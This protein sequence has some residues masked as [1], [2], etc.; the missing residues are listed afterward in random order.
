[1][2]FLNR[3]K[4]KTQLNISFILIII[5]ITFSILSI[6]H[7]TIRNSFRNHE[8]QI[9]YSFGQQIAVNI[10]SRTQ[11]FMS[12][13]QIIRTNQDF[14]YLLQTDDFQGARERLATM[15]MEFMSLNSGRVRDITL[16]KIHLH[17]RES[18]DTNRYDMISKFHDNNELFLGDYFIT[19]TFLNER[20]ERVFSIF[21]KIYQTNDYFYFVEICIY[22][23][24]FFIFFNED[25]SDSEIFI[26]KNDYIM[27][28]NARRLFDRVLRYNRDNNIPYSTNE[29]FA[30]SDASILIED[31]S[32][33][34]SVI[35]DS[36][37][38][39]LLRGYHQLLMMLIPYIL[40]ILIGSFVFVIIFSK[41]FNSKLKALHEKTTIISSWK[42]TDDLH[43][44]GSDEFAMLGHELDETRIR[45]L[46]LI[47]QNS[48]I[49]DSLR[50][51]E[52]S[53]LRAQI[54]SHFLFN[55]LSSIK[56]LS[57][58]GESEVLRDAVDK[59]AIFLRYS[60]S[61]DE[62]LVSLD[63]ELQQLEAY[64]YLQKL[65][66]GNKI[67][68]TIDVPQ[69]LIT[70]KTAKLI[71]QPLVENAIYHGRRDGGEP[72]N[73]VIYGLLG[74]GYY[75][76]IVE[77]NGLGVPREKIDDIINDSSN[78]DDGSY[79]LRNVMKR[80]ALS[81]GDTGKTFIES[82]VGKFTKITIR[83]NIK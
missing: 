54:N 61:L 67:N 10:E 28:T 77:D 16:H 18:S 13:L 60:L 49:N 32:F 53:A 50:M 4:F 38:D 19:Y 31:D 41:N 63:R 12:Y 11:Y 58:E 14:L 81:S 73:I 71:L 79:G 21:K 5:F 64:I 40:L 66:F 47:H 17:E 69:N 74:N 20:N 23:T 3:F 56:W 37:Q 30:I 29:D 45:I 46:E 8:N 6:L 42:L 34:F 27:S 24:E 39:Y 80:I 15:S 36:N 59:L 33:R 68:I 65:R 82:E 35:I 9:L 48:K 70:F 78:I 7:S 1:M 44:G 55:S 83:Q 72:L 26:L 52:M 43:I 25:S 75:D 76:L 62:N 22:E 51:L 57:K 2:K